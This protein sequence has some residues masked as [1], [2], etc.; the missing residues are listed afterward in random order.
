MNSISILLP[1]RRISLAYNGNYY[2][3]KVGGKEM[4]LS[5]CKLITIVPQKKGPNRI[6]D[7]RK[8][9]CF[10]PKGCEKCG[11]NKHEE[12]RRMAEEKPHWIKK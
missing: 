12:A 3:V 7:N 8:Y 10:D 2:L 9:N 1:I 11:M 6:I 4:K 5:D